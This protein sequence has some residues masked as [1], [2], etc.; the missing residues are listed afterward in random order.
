MSIWGPA[1]ESHRRKTAR[2]AVSWP[3]R[4]AASHRTCRRLDPSPAVPPAHR[5]LEAGRAQPRAEPRVLEQRP[6]RQ[7]APRPQG[8]RRRAQ[9]LLG[10]EALVAERRERR[11]P[12]IDV[13]QD[14]VVPRARA[15]DDC[16]DVAFDHAEA[17]V[18]QRRP[19]QVAKDVAVPAHDGTDQLDD[20]R[21]V[22]REDAERRAR[23]EAHAEA[24]DE[25][26]RLRLRRQPG[27]TKHSG[28]SE[29]WLLLCIRS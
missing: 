12:V 27:A 11:R 21:G 15:G 24:A 1:T 6:D 2:G 13:E 9:P 19:R 26:A 7:H 22:G 8:A 16:G 23:R 29:P 4:P 25:H 5:H 28:S 18:A 17:G 3:G 10:V 20:H 14:G